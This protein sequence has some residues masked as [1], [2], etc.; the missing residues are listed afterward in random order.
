MHKLNF[1]FFILFSY[2]CF[3][4]SV[5]PYFPLS[6]SRSSLERK[7]ENW[8]ALRQLE[9][10]P[11]TW[12][13]ITFEQKE[14]S[15]LPLTKKDQYWSIQ[16]PVYDHTEKK[17][18]PFGFKFFP[19]KKYNAETSRLVVIYPTIEGETIV[20]RNLARMALN[21]GHHV[22][23]APIFDFEYKSGK[24][25]ISDIREKT[26]FGVKAVKT[27]FDLLEYSYKNKDFPHQQAVK[28]LGLVRPEQILQIGVSNGTVGA[29][30]VSQT[31]N[32]VSQQL[33]IIPIG[34]VPGVFATTTNEKIAKFRTEQMDYYG[35]SDKA[36]FAKLVKETL[37][38]DPLDY[39]DSHLSP[40]TLAFFQKDDTTVPGQ[41]Q[42]EL[43]S[44][45]QAI[46][47]S[48]QL[49]ITKTNYDSALRLLESFKRKGV[50][51][52]ELKPM[53]DEISKFDEYQKNRVIYA[54]HEQ[55]NRD[56]LFHELGFGHVKKILSI[57]FF[58][59]K[60][61]KKFIQL[62]I[63]FPTEWAKEDRSFYI[64]SFP[65][66]STKSILLDCKKALESNE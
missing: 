21:D 2:S 56:V 9:F 5:E 30:M 47:V 4:E 32:R 62:P 26:L 64:R 52:T 10:D 33:L 43:L 46:V 23:I 54:M 42:L 53:Y 31:D 15:L 14:Q 60:E 45:I 16:L 61:I 51:D 17:M 12:P 3:A 58:F 65:I 50:S 22:L 25:G 39:V 55:Q 59:N 38:F 41:F 44:R 57:V 11:R 49:D 1:I 40:Q 29:Y 37:R 35:I 7:V 20:E 66:G 8:N 28:I 36:E 6:G 18:K 63:K 27:F 13:E 34:N 48:Q 19:S 24:E